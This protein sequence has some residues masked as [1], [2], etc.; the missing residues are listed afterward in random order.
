MYMNVFV[1]IA[2]QYYTCA[3]KDVIY[4]ACITW[5]L[6]YPIGGHDINNY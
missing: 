5:Y 3:S 1:K 2:I 4:F 6:D